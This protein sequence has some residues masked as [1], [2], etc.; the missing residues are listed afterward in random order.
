M[1]K[2]SSFER[3]ERDYYKT[4]FKAAKPLFPHLPFGVKFCEPCAGNGRLINLL[5]GYAQCVA[6]YDI[7]PD[8]TWIKQ[9]DATQLTILDLNGANM[10]ITNPPWTRD[11]LHPI[12]E[13]CSML[14]PTW[15][16]FDADWMHTRQSQPYMGI[17]QSIVS[18]GRV[19]WIDDSPHLGKDNCCWY[20]FDATF[21]GQTQFYG[22]QDES[23]T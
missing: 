14:A 11:I 3:F 16:L 7:E 23:N 10:I 9:G 15:L 18:V 4:P 6:S 12:I 20:L 17:C 5:G 1:G 21:K 22:R 13:R 8:A 2:R 19:K